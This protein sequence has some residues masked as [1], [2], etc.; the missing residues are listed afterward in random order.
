M[1]KFMESEVANYMPTAAAN[2]GFAR[3]AERDESLC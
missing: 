3:M 2:L 1:G